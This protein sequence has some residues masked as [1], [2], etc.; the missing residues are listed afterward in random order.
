MIPIR[1]PA[2]LLLASERQLNRRVLAS[3]EQPDWIPRNEA[4]SFV[5]LVAA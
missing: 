2:R 3:G 4:R 5:E 1:S